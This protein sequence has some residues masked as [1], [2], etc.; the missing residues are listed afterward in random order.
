MGILVKT[1][2]TYQVSTD[3]DA[4]ELIAEAMKTENV[5]ASSIKVKNIKE[6][7]EIVDTYRLVAITVEG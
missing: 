2:K 1:V 7:G 5:T 4:R 6:K 3:T